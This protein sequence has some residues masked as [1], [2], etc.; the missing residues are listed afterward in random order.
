MAFDAM[1]GTYASLEGIFVGTPKRQWAG[2]PLSS[3]DKTGVTSSVVA[4]PSGLCGDEQA[5]RKVHGGPDKAVCFYPSQHYRFWNEKLHPPVS[6]EPGS[7]GE[8]ISSKIFDEDNVCIGDIFRLGDAEI[9]VTQGRTPC[10]KLN[11]YTGFAQMASL[12]LRTGRT[13]WYFRVLRA[14]Q[15]GPGNSLELLRRCNPGF[16]VRFVTA[17]RTS[18]KHD[19]DSFHLLSELDGLSA[20]WRNSFRKKA[21]TK[22]QDDPSLAWKEPVSEI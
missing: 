20:G 21:E 5:D 15:F 1:K 16:S 14:G 10:W 18:M 11:K 6:F 2:R 7:F 12:F 8:N 3:I 13:G 4:R 19:A 9:Q 22:N 17:S